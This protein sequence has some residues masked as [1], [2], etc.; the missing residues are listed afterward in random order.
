MLPSTDRAVS[1]FTPA[2]R[3]EPV[4]LLLAQEKGNHPPSGALAVDPAPKLSPLRCAAPLVRFMLRWNLPS[5]RYQ[6]AT[7]VF[8]EMTRPF[9]QMLAPE[10]APCDSQ[11]AN[12]EHLLAHARSPHR[13]LH[14]RARYLDEARAFPTCWKRLRAL[15][16]CPLVVSE[17]A[18]P[19]ACFPESRCT[20]SPWAN[21]PSPP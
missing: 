18:L 16:V 12:N 20:S 3:H 13:G 17:Q 11:V 14:D 7:K 21:K 6:L 8:A 2:C 10:S 5:T 4:P 19:P 1:S 15:V 9:L